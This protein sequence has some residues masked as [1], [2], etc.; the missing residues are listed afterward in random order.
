MNIK[1]ATVTEIDRAALLGEDGDLPPKYVAKENGVTGYGQTEE[2][3]E[4]N[5]LDGQSF[6]QHTRKLN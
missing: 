1:S 3:A 4:K 5:C 6:R 2:E